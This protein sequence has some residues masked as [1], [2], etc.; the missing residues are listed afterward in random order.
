MSLQPHKVRGIERYLLDENLA[1]EPLHLHITEVA[2]GARSHPPHQHDGY[3]AVYML[4]GEGTLELGDERYIL[5]ATEALVFD[6]RKLHGL[7]NHSNAPMRYM[8][9]L[10]KG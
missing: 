7:I 6:P 5:R 3:E 10:A 9:V 2:P 8:V 4:E 1:D